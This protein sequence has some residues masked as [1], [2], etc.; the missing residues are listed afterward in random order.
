MNKQ[1]QKVQQGFT[2][3]ELMIVVAIIGILAA[4]AIPAYQDYIARAQA[5]EGVELLGGLKT[6]IAEFA[7]TNGALADVGDL[8]EIKGTGKYVESVTGTDGVFVALFKSASI[9][10]KL[11]GENITMT[12]ATADGGSFTFT[13][14]M[15]TEIQPNLCK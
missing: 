2:L 3:I 4:I 11:K 7:N 9:S 15:P 8:G 13:C 14:S 10:D 5:S 1:M 12:F 6:P